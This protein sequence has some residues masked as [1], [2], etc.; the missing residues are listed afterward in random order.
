MNLG[1]GLN[2]AK[3]GKHNS[4]RLDA[5]CRYLMFDYRPGQ[6]VVE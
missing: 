3:T 2:R 1:A 6:V 5:D 4:G